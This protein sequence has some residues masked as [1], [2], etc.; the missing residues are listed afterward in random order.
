MHRGARLAPEP[1][2]DGVGAAEGLYILAVNGDDVVAGGDAGLLGRGT[3]VDLQDL[4]VA[5]LVLGQLHTNAHQDAVLDVQQLGVG[6]GGVVP[7]VTVAGAHQVARRDGVIQQ[8]LV[9]GVVVI[10][11]DVAVQL[12]NLAVHVLFFLHVA[13]GAVKQPHGQQHGDREGHGHGQDDDGQHHPHRDFLIHRRLLSAQQHRNGA[14][15]Q[16]QCQQP[17]QDDARDA[18]KALVFI[19]FHTFIPPLCVLGST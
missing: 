11:A 6:L 15:Q 17:C 19:G 2:L 5:G 3:V 8:G 13:D 1:G 12:S 10:A 18:L 14:A 9:N 4:G 7:G 16:R